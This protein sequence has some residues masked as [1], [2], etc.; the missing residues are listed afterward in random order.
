MTPTVSTTTHKVVAAATAAIATGYALFRYLRLPA[1][2]SR[3]H[4]SRRVAA[5]R[6]CRFRPDV[7]ENTIE[8][9]AYAHS[10]GV[11]TVELDVRICRSGELVVFHDAFC[12]PLLVPPP[13]STLSDPA[14]ATAYAADRV[15]FEDL[16]LEEIRTLRYARRVDGKTVM[17]PAAAN[18]GDG[19]AAG[20]GEDQV[21]ATVD[22]VKVPTLEEAIQ[23][24]EA[25][26][27]EMLIEL[28]SYSLRPAR[29]REMADAYATLYARHRAYLDT[30][31]T[32]IS[33]HPFLLYMVRCRIPS[34]AVCMLEADDMICDLVKPAP[35]RPYEL[36]PTVL[37][38]TP[39][40]VL[41]ALDAARLAFERG[42]MFHFVRPSMQG[43]S[44]E[45]ITPAY[46]DY[47]FDRR[48][49]VYVWGPRKTSQV[50]GAEHW[51]RSGLCISCDDDYDTYAAAFDGRSAS[52]ATV[53]TI[54][55][56][57]ASPVS[58]EATPQ[59]KPVAP[60][61]IT[62]TD[63]AAPLATPVPIEDSPPAVAVAVTVA[64]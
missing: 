26:G 8:A 24:C 27:L 41:R 4:W 31:T 50:S 18:G 63:D 40:I 35:A 56:P 9:F 36:V 57:A 15:S 44:W 33:F 5:H 17:V 21:P 20:G 53:A 43:P 47:Y 62:P 16:T 48:V 51:R 25:H 6:G 45:M 32:T 49:T 46:L 54:C 23:F 1:S 19:A 28:K 29:L 34:A 39:G 10:K 58:S 7:P 61:A 64:A 42:V 14:A 52:G 38:Y 13:L 59:P 37:L 22:G 3:L 11:K 12:D 2:P 30:A 60:P 55:S